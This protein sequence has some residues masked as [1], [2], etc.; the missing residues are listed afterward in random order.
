MT[1][2]EK[3]NLYWDMKQMLELIESSAENLKSYFPVND[4]YYEE[5]KE[6]DK[7]SAALDIARSGVVQKPW[8]KQ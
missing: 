5:E 6:E 8:C 1:D 2:S 4:D 7:E 3:E